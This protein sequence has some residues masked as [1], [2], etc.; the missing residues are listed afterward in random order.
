[1]NRLL[2]KFFDIRPGEG[3]RAML[4][5]AY[6]FLII[7]SLLIV[8]PVR[9]SLFLTTFGVAQLPYAFILV[10]LISALF[11][12]LYSRF[13]PKIRLN[14]LILNTIIISIVLF[15]IFWL[16]L[17]LDYQGGWFLYAFY[18]WVA[19]FGVVLTMQFWL[20]ANYV[21]NAREAKRLF[22]FVGAGAISGG[23]FGG[24]LTNYL[25]PLI[26]T[27]SMILICMGFLTACIFLLRLI[28]IKGA[29][30][31]YRDQIRQQRRLRQTQETRYPIK[32]IL[33]SKHLSY[34]AGIVGIGVIVASLVDY[35]YSAVASAVITDEDEL[36]AFFGFWFSNLSIVSLAIQL[37][38]TR[39]VLQTLGVV[40]S[41]FF[42][43][44]GILIGAITILITPALWAAILIKVADGGFK[45]SINKAALEILYLPVA[46]NIKNQAKT[47][48]DVLVDS[49]ATGIGGILLIVLIA[50]WGLTV[51]HVSIMI[52]GL[53]ALWVVLLHKIRR[54]Y[55]DSFRL[56][57][58]KRSINI[59]EEFINLQDASILKSITGI[60][61]S[62]NEKQILYALTLL[63]GVKRDDFL[64]HLRELLQHRSEEIRIKTLQFLREYRNTDWSPEVMPL[65]E[66][67]SA[68]V[69][70]EALQYLLERTQDKTAFLNGFLN[71]PDYRVC[72]SALVATAR[73]MQRDKNL[74]RHLNM[75]ELF[76]NRM[77]GYFA[78]DGDAEAR[79]MKI[80]A[81]EVIGI[82]NDP[83]LYSYLKRLLN[84][85]SSE[86]LQAAI[87]NA[88]KTRSGEFLPILLDHL[89]TKV[90]R[91]HARE[92]LS[93]YGE[94]I[95]EK[96]V[97]RMNDPQESANVRLGIPKVL[98]MIGAQK[99][100][101]ALIENLKR[102][103]LALRY[104][105]LKALNKLNVKF[106][107]LKFDKNLINE[108]IVKETR[109][110][111]RILTILHMQ[112]QRREE[113]QEARALLIRALEEKLDENLERIFRLL[114]LKYLQQDMYNAYLSIKSDK[115]DLRANAVEFLDNV[116]DFELKKFIIP[117]VEKNPYNYLV[118]KSGEFFGFSLPDENDC[119]ALLLKGNDMWLKSCALFLLAELK[120]DQCLDLMKPLRNDA[121]PV[122]SETAGYALNKV[123][124]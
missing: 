2:S 89:N 9:N 18:V 12:F 119:L 26:G 29:R 87:I 79:L 40:T 78:G 123:K 10:A 50:G 108:E 39:R 91:R 124:S 90:A 118:E 107:I 32:L 27:E 54:E 58:E 51:G 99:S 97:Q 93:E 63:E 75:S 86:V 8:K 73:E 44:A 115:S 60:L 80:S 37:F 77:K 16:L 67:E 114:G 88:G 104:Q 42:L 71:H 52:M 34:L 30:H 56:A 36:T 116:L 57:I 122:V 112:S 121:N 83:L 82:S 81:A 102:D 43:P 85:S 103:D 109:N 94:E 47:V 64:P 72:G 105:T 14:I 106:S 46:A 100:V 48:V 61:N 101:N 13:S 21:F 65:V 59:E 110:Y 49:L 55:V 24:Y 22:G 35:Q 76:E 5:F 19:I 6:I 23:I 25:A 92:A 70:T 96:L 111:Y 117:I 68:A 15:G 7:A 45:Q 11:T 38:L 69:R 98:A 41:L 62:S 20:L 84:D 31:S 3:L 17:F 95:V 33:R 113:V 53:V 120:N 1:M 74:Q 28:W 4:M 66:D